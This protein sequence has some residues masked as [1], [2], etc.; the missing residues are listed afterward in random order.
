MS[1]FLSALSAA[2]LRSAAAVCNSLRVRDI[3]APKGRSHALVEW[4]RRTDQEVPWWRRRVPARRGQRRAPCKRTNTGS[5]PI[6]RRRATD[7]AG[8]SSGPGLQHHPAAG[9]RAGWPDPAGLQGLRHLGGRRLP[10]AERPAAVTVLTTTLP[11]INVKTWLPG[12]DEAG[13]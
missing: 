2:Q 1:T 9:L 6:V 10:E 11:T 5:G 8:R 12:D 4:Y 7:S 13:S 3:F